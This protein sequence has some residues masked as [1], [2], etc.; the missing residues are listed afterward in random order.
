MTLMVGST[1]ALID[2]V[3]QPNVS[4]LFITLNIKIMTYPYKIICTLY[5]GKAR[6]TC[7]RQSVYS[8]SVPSRRA[9]SRSSTPCARCALHSAPRPSPLV[10][11]C[12]IAPIGHARLF[13]F[14]KIFLFSP[15]THTHQSFFHI[16][17]QCKRLLG[18]KSTIFNKIESSHSVPNGFLENYRGLSKFLFYT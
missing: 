10:T 6:Q 1:Y 15:H 17:F 2:I 4:T 11:P 16:F 3:I 14:G 5:S 12:R 18:G 13:C 8:L 9:S 7:R